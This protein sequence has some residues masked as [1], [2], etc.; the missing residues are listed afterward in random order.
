LDFE[1]AASVYHLARV[2]YIDMGM[3]EAELNRFS[4]PRVFKTHLPHKYLP[5]GFQNTGKVRFS[6]TLIKL[7]SNL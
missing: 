6:K 2:P 5:D 7:T 3:S 4:S 1:A